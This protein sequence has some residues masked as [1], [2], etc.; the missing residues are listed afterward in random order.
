MSFV[1]NKIMATSF[2]GYKY[3]FENKLLFFSKFH[4]LSHR[5]SYTCKTNSNISRQF[6][7][8]SN[9]CWNITMFSTSHIQKI[10]IWNLS[11]WPKGVTAIPY[12]SSRIQQK[13]PLS[14]L[15]SSSKSLLKNS[16]I[17]QSILFT[18]KIF[19]K[20]FTV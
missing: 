5:D 2:Y 17:I 4:K 11:E 9:Q 7:Y 1:H 15:S 20:T 10:I 12:F 3:Y 16:W 13:K 8:F 6:V 14:P 18:M 19:L